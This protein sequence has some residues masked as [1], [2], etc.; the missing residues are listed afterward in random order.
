MKTALIIFSALVLT[1]LAG[2]ETAAKPDQS[3]RAFCVFLHYG[4]FLHKPVQISQ[5]KDQAKEQPLD[6]SKELLSVD[7]Q[8]GQTLRYKFTSYRSIHIITKDPSRR[9]KENI[10]KNHETF[11]MV[12]AY[13]PVE[14][15]PYGPTTIKATCKSVITKRSSSRPRPEATRTLS[16]KTFTFTVSPTGKIEDYSQLRKLIRQTGEKAFRA[17]SERGKIKD[18]DMTGDFIATQWFLWDPISSIMKPTE[19][20]SVGQTWKSKLS[21]PTPMIMQQARDV[22]YRLDG[23][24]RNEKGRLAVISS[25]FSPAQSTP[26]SWPIPY[27]DG[28]FQMRGK[29]GFYRGYKVLDLQGQGEE[30]YNID[31]GRTE[32][33][34]HQYQMLLKASAPFGIKLDL[35]MVVNQKLIMRLLEDD[36]SQ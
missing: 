31:A 10:D 4:Q 35:Q 9:G 32:K 1:A 28:T 25:S 33:Y 30:L 2:C 11:E 7:F 6:Q 29:F 13:T 8:K 15:D 24:R 26:K 36:V 22:T 19:G 21:V 34:Y 14:I 17:E 12:V 23:I 3:N 18:P 16:G 20:V 5:K 27:P